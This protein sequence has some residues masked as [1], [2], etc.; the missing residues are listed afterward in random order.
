MEGLVMC[1]GAL[2]VRWC[3][4][5]GVGDGWRHSVAVD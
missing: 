5:Q 1:T 4:V 3:R 2:Q